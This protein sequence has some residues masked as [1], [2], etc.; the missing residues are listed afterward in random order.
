MK[1]KKRQIKATPEQ[2][3]LWDSNAATRIQQLSVR[4]VDPQMVQYGQYVA[5]ALNEMV[6]GVHQSV[7]QVG[8]VQIWAT[9]NRRL[10]ETTVTAVPYRTYNYGGQRRFAYAPLVSQNL[11]LGGAQTTATAH[12]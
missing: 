3:A 9:L 12:S 5:S 2:S 6:Y 4:N 1:F 10:G 7:N 8:E 11:N